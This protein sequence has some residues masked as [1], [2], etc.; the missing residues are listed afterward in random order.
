MASERDF[1]AEEW[2]LITSAPAAA[3]L[4]VTMAD[5]SGPVGIAKEAMSVGR[6]VLEA[7]ESAPGELLKA[8]GSSVKAAGKLERPDVPTDRTHMKQALL[9]IVRNAAAA[10]AAKSAA[11]GDQFR[12]FLLEVARRAAD[13]SKEGGV[14]GIGGVRQSESEQAMLAELDRVLGTAAST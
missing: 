11:E 12:A 14:L 8:L 5:M 10:V 1:T 9:D 3:G 4:L 6:A 7:T 13:A 2:K